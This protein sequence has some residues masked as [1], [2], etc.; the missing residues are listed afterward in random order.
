MLA[1]LNVKSR[2]K[3]RTKDKN[4]D[5]DDQ[6]DEQR[7]AETIDTT[8]QATGSCCAMRCPDDVDLFYEEKID[9][10][11]GDCVEL[12]L[13]GVRDCRVEEREEGRTRMQEKIAS[14]QFKWLAERPA[15]D[16]SKPAQ[17]IKSHLS[18]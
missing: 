7:A 11:L 8:L 2:A 10:E 15:P 1:F 12:R 5:Y 18:T 16:M 6:R 17:K 3:Y 9:K 4:D 13:S 14:E